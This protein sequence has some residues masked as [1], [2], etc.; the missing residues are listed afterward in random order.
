M[1]ADARPR[2]ALHAAITRLM[3]PLVRVLL[4]HSLPFSAFEEIARQ[5]YVDVALSEFAIP[6]KKP[7]ISRAS[8]LTGLTRKE[9][10]RRLAAPADPDVEVGEHYNRAARVL[11]GWTRD[12][13]FQD[14]EGNP[15]AI[16]LDGAFSFAALVRR[17]SG[18]MPARAVLDELLRAG[19][20]RRREDGRFEPVARAYVP[21][22]NAI[23]KLGIL[24]SDVADLI[25]TIDH[26]IQHGD[27]DPRFQ[28][29][30]LYHSIDTAALPAFRK[31]S[32]TQ[33]QA[34]LE[35][36]D[37]WLAGRDEAPTAPDAVRA[38]VGL[39]IYY[40]EERAGLGRSGDEPS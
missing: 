14:A 18:D 16:G 26:N 22:R 35:R 37:R 31:L 15:K 1:D 23:E 38:R 12:A 25:D 10:Q 7:S 2:Q 11:T 5:V 20:V 3:R 39:G 29:K 36:M 34:L 4:R 13:D 40:I 19:A 32:A 33:A 21:R 17:H 30:V 24:G 28:R 8:I 27:T 9:V 6:G